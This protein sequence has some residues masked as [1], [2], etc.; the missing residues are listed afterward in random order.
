MRGPHPYEPPATNLRDNAPDLELSKQ[1]AGGEAVEG[2]VGANERLDLDEE[3]R[4]ALVGVAEAEEGGGGEAVAAL[5][6]RK[7]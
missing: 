3:R 4:D 6:R 1:E 2:G 5:L 7:I